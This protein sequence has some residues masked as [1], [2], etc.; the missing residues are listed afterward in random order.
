[1]E[2]P[3]VPV[4]F[5]ERDD[6]GRVSLM[7]ADTRAFIDSEGI[8]LTEGLRLH[9]CQPSALGRTLDW[10]V[11]DGT[12]TFDTATGR[13]MA[14]LVSSIGRASES[15]ADHWSRRIPPGWRGP[16]AAGPLLASEIAKFSVPRVNVIESEDGY[17][18]EVLGLTGLRYTEP[19]RTIF[20]DS[21][22]LA[23]DS[24]AALVI[25]PSRIKRWD[26][27]HSAEVSD[28]E[29]QQIVANIEKA[30]L[31]RDVHIEIAG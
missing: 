26:P 16:W 11:A 29:R 14:E 17:S 21:E 20:V 23:S 31:F 3:L 19:P 30:F 24:S 22:M 27:P 18:V 10:Q 1:M 12:A 15:D 5:R 28:A 2:T 4:R 6:S 7:N 13:W 8:A 25:Y 9:L